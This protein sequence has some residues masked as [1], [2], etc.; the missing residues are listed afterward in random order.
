MMTFR[1]AV[2]V[3]VNGKYAW[4]PPLTLGPEAQEALNQALAQLLPVL[5]GDMIEGPGIH[6]IRFEDTAD[7]TRGPNTDP[8]TIVSMFERNS[9]KEKP[10]DV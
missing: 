5:F 1:A 3:R 7:P 6:G 4:T 2:L 10:N 8:Q 9:S